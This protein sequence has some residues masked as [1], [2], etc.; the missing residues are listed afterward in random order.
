LDGLSQHALL[1]DVTTKVLA[2]NLATLLLLAVSMVSGGIAQRIHHSMGDSQS[3]DSVWMG[4]YH[5]DLLYSAIIIFS[6]EGLHNSLRS[7]R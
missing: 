4:S 7:C 1:V 5:T 2:D 6:R 3:A